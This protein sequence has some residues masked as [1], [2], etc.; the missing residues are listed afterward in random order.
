MNASNVELRRASSFLGRRNCVFFRFSGRLLLGDSKTT[1]VR[2]RQI[3]K[4]SDFQKF[5]G[6]NRLHFFKSG[7]RFQDSENGRFHQGDLRKIG[8]NSVFGAHI[9]KNA[10]ANAFFAQNQMKPDRVTAGVPSDLINLM[11]KMALLNRDSD[12]KNGKKL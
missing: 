10:A 2:F 5:S 6:R 1:K 9:L 8:K 3:F 12:L 7:G 4:I 11:A